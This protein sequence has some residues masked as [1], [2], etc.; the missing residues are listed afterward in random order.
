ML[1]VN[2]FFKA[3]M[4]MVATCL[5]ITANASVNNSPPSVVITT[6][7]LWQ[8]YTGTAHVMIAAT[9][10]DFDGNIASVEFM[11]NGITMGTDTSYPYY[12]GTTLSVGVHTLTAKATD[13]DGNESYHSTQITVIRKIRTGLGALIIGATPAA[14]IP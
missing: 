13:N 11:V 5:V 12:V 6:P 10:A 4:L 2:H 9:A 7:S 14:V 8:T 3:T 1:K